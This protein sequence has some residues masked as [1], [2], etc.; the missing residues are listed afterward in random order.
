M[1]NSVSGEPSFGFNNLQGDCSIL[2]RILYRCRRIVRLIPLTL[3]GER[4]EHGFEI[5]IRARKTSCQ[6]GW[7][8]PLCE[9]AVISRLPI[10]PVRLIRWSVN[11]CMRTTANKIRFWLETSSGEQHPPVY[12]VVPVI[13]GVALTD[14]VTAFE[15]SHH[16]DPAGGY[17]GIVPQ[18]YNYGPLDS[19]LMGQFSADSCWANL[20]G[21]YILGCDCGEVG[22]WPLICRVTI[23]DGTVI[24]DDFKQPHRPERDYSQF[25]P[26]V[27]DDAQYRSAV[28]ELQAQYAATLAAES[29]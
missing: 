8:T 22:C 27:F 26:F 3:F 28:R 1:E 19:Y 5:R 10:D 12:A 17:G 18:F 4:V 13:D 24:W 21:I 9:S 15:R 6:E 2:V 29:G 16:L 20:G 14:L 11:Q 25:G 7:L 23:C